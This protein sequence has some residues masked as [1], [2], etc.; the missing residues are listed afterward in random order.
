MHAATA[1]LP[2]RGAPR[3]VAPLGRLLA[4]TLLV[5]ALHV[6]VLD[7]LSGQWQTPSSLREM[8]APMYTRLVQPSVPAPAAGMA[9]ESAPAAAAGGPLTARAVGPTPAPRPAPRQAR[10]AKPAS[11]PTAAEERT[12]T[13]ASAASAP[14]ANGSDADAPLA[15]AAPDAPPPDAALV[16]D[17]APADS[18]PALADADPDEAASA[19]AAAAQAEA[20]L[21]PAQR[22]ALERWPANTRLRYQLSGHYNGE[23]HGNARVLWQREG[24]RYQ[25]RVELDLGLLL[26][27]A[28]TSQGRIAGDHL[29][30]SVYEERIRRKRRAVTL[31]EQTLHFNNGEQAPRPSDVQDTASQFIEITHRFTTGQARL[32]VGES[33]RFDLARPTGVDPWVYDVVGESTLHLPRLGPT[34]VYQL[35]PRRAAPG[36][37]NKLTAEM[38]IA[39]SLQY[40]PVRIR[41]HQD[42]E[43]YVDL[44]VT[45]IEQDGGPAGGR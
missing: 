10:P 39:P 15:N 4:W 8:A 44:M 22:A 19:P 18:A 12:H 11:A 14:E 26:D 34:Q 45:T 9:A 32:K 30:P 37:S 7:W 16:P 28:L 1:F 40:L 38:W 36:R 2:P 41:I 17:P 21:T 27:M 29:A 5:L 25:A 13:A 24:E 6:L 33:I 35:S 42:D 23:L 3:A 20:V 43:R 31:G